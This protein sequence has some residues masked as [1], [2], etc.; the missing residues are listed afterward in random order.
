MIQ[1]HKNSDGTYDASIRGQQLG[2]KCSFWFTARSVAMSRV[3]QLEAKFEV[4][5]H[6]YDSDYAPSTLLTYLDDAEKKNIREYNVYRTQFMKA[7]KDGNNWLIVEFR[8][9]KW[10]GTIRRYAIRSR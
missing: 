3:A 1:T 7:G 4:K 6:D 5:S 8:E 2:L 9:P 10:D